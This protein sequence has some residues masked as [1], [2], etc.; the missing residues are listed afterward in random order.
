MIGEFKY[1]KL[2]RY[3]HLRPEEVEMYERLLVHFPT[4]FTSVDFD[5]RVGTGQFFP[6]ILPK[7]I[8]Q[9]GRE[10]SKWRI[11]FVGYKDDSTTIV[12]LKTAARASAIGQL[13]CY[14]ILYE[15]N[16]TNIQNLNLLLVT[17]Q[18]VPDLK[19]CASILN[20]KVIKL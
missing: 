16:V 17:D 15:R 13:T 14:K 3:P 1:E 10:L 11:D 12:E 4:L 9:D 18:V 8:H 2:H 19:Y 6:G 20:I 7:E 5:V